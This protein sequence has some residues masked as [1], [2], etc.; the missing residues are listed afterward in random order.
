MTDESPQ[1]FPT[2]EAV[3]AA[4]IRSVLIATRWNCSESARIL[5]IDRRTIYRQIARY[6]IERPPEEKS[7]APSS[8][9]G[10]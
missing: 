1:T 7:P 6:K 3:I 9:C 2:I 5:G 10:E 8:A 4:H